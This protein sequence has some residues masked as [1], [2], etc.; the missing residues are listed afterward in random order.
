MRKQSDC[1]G[2]FLN[3]FKSKENLSNTEMIDITGL[4]SS[5]F[6]EYIKYEREPTIQN[7][8]KLKNNM[9]LTCDELLTWDT[10]SE[11]QKETILD[12]IHKHLPEL[13]FKYFIKT[14]IMNFYKDQKIPM[15]VK[16]EVYSFIKDLYYDEKRKAD[17]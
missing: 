10:M 13:R 3:D 9:G 7:V 6:Y 11:I 15:F 14:N 4:S 12:R 1:I 17:I 5:S 2:L 8:L 16:E